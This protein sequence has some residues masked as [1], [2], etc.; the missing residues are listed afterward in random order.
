MLHPVRG[1][2]T[3][4]EKCPPE[5]INAKINL[6]MGIFSQM[7]LGHSRWSAHTDQ[8]AR[9]KPGLS[10]DSFTFLKW[11]ILINNLINNNN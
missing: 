3:C 7:N 1:D 2:T 5:F 10:A 9:W 11:Y 6:L 8:L 4:K